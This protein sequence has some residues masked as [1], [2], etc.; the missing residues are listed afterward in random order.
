M[1]KGRAG[2]IARQRVREQLKAEQQ[3]LQELE[4]TR[5]EAVE[6]VLR[7][8]S[9]REDARQRAAEAEVAAGAALDELLETG[10]DREAAGELVDLTPKELGQ[11]IRASR[12][13]AKAAGSAADEAPNES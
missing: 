10:V 8:L 9:D 12:R 5:T 2:Q 13:Q 3:R 7:H 6:K 1:A 11:M 4:Q